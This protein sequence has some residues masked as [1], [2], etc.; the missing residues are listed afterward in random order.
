[1]ELQVREGDRTDEL[2][3]NLADA[4]DEHEE[5]EKLDD[6]VE[7]YSRKSQYEQSVLVTAAS[8]MGVKCYAPVEYRAPSKARRPS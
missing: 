5:E 7:L 8:G 4:V 2:E 1:M 6:L 3:Q